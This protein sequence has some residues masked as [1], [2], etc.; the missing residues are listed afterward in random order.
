MRTPWS[1]G[2]E[3]ELMPD[4]FKDTLLNPCLI[5]EVLSD[6]TRD[7][8]LTPKFEMYK[9]IPSFREYLAIEQDSVCVRHFRMEEPGRWDHRELRSLG[10]VIQFS[11]VAAEMSLSAVYRGIETKPSLVA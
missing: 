10:D 4:Q 9:D 2:G 5:V 1:I 6:A 3:P 8:D 7:Y 11:S